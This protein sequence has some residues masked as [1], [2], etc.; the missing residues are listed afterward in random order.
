[1][2]FTDM[3]AVAD[4]MRMESSMSFFQMGSAISLQEK[5]RQVRHEICQNRRQ[6]ASVRLEAITGADNPS[7]LIQVFRRGHIIAKSGAVAFV[8]RCNPVEV[9]PRAASNCTEEIP[10]T[11]NGPSLFVDP[12]R[13]VLKSAASPIRC[14]DIAPPRWNIAGRWYCSYPAI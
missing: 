11:W 6:T 7:S 4:V 14:D 5:I 1:V 2:K 3:P 10:V 12:V 13:Y 9:V 8:T